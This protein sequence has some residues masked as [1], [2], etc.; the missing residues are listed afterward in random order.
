MAKDDPTLEVKNKRLVKRLVLI[1]VLMFGFAYL[2]VPMYRL[3]CKHVGLNGQADNTAA[4]APHMDIDKSRLIEVEFSTTVHGALPFQF[5]PLVHHIKLHP[6][7]TKLVYFYAQNNAKTG[8]TVQAIPS[9]TPD[10]SAKH[11]RKTQCFCFTRQYF[12]PGEKA[13]MPVYFYVDSDLPKDIND[14]TLSYT[15]FNA[16]GYAKKGEK[17]SQ[18]RID[19]N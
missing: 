12:F 10:E 6:G 3:V 2:M 15:L 8:M 11:L 1:A 17:F 9:I 4:L 19:L 16:N 14:I 5:K 18:G 7:E 13:D